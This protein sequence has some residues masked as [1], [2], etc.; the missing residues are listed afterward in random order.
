MPLFEYK[1]KNE[2]VISHVVSFDNR[3]EPQVCSK[4]GEPSQFEISFC[5]TFNYSA[6]WATVSSEAR[7]WNRRENHRLGTQNKSYA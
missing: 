1:C 4:C 7:S 2:H 5:T 6:D 3:K